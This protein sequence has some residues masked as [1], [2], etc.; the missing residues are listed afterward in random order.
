MSASNE[1]KGEDGTDGTPGV[2][3]WPVDAWPRQYEMIATTHVSLTM[4]WP[5]VRLGSDR[6]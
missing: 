5:A 3:G 1:A 4:R 6:P 2:V